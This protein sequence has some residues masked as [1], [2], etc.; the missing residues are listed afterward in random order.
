[1]VNRSYAI[2]ADNK[3]VDPTADHFGVCRP[4][5]K[6]AATYTILQQFIASALADVMIRRY[7]GRKLETTSIIFI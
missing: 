1:M 4:A 6:E 3:Y 7:A 2:D 5:S